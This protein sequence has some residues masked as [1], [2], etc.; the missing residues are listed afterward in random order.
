MLCQILALVK[1]SFSGMYKRIHYV[2][3]VEY[4]QMVIFNPEMLQ[5]S[6]STL[7]KKKEK[8]KNSIIS[9][10]GT[11]GIPTSLQIELVVLVFHYIYILIF[12][13][14]KQTL[15][16]YKLPQIAASLLSPIRQQGF[17]CTRHC[18]NMKCLLSRTLHSISNNR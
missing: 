18:A 4:W 16:L 9:S 15:A 2:F 14:L 7:W 1:L 3:Y 12:V 6:Q 13:T 10:W 11:C 8:I 17:C 5:N